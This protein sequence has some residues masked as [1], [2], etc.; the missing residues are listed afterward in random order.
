VL[1]NT[2]VSY[3]IC[4]VILIL[5]SHCGVQWTASW[6]MQAITEVS[7]V[8]KVWF[9]KDIILKNPAIRACSC[10]CFITMLD[11]GTINSGSVV[12]WVIGHP[13]MAV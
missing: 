4:S 8:I 5:V 13:S 6:P 12:Q 9:I 1:L 10:V 2:A 11:T 3:P 7:W